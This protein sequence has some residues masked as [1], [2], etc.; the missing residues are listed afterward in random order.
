MAIQYKSHL[1]VIGTGTY[2][3]GYA[4]WGL[5]PVGRDSLF[6]LIL[7]SAPPFALAKAPRPQTNIKN[8]MVF[9][10]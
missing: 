6:T 2:T 4:N 10:S 8:V 7:L 3:Y 9:S 1:V 5:H